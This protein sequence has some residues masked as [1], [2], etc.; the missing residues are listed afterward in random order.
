MLFIYSHLIVLYLFSCFYFT[1]NNLRRLGGVLPKPCYPDVRPN[2][3]SS[4]TVAEQ[5]KQRPQQH[6]VPH[7]SSHVSSSV[8]SSNINTYQ[9]KGNDTDRTERSDNSYRPIIYG[10]PP[11]KA[12]LQAI[13]ENNHNIPRSVYNPHQQAPQKISHQ[14]SH[15]VPTRGAAPVVRKYPPPPLHQPSGPII[16]QVSS[17]F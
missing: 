12:P 7:I 1:G 8:A 13:T 17:I 5:E 4:W 9:N 10:V 16:S 3:P 11:P 15:Q 14:V 2:S 6:A